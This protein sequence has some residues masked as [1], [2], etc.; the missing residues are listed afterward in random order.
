MTNPSTLEQIVMRRVYRMRYLRMV[1]NEF[2]A[3]LLLL[4]A[5]LWGLGREVWVAMVLHNAPADLLRAPAFFLSAFLDTR[6]VVQLLSMLVLAAV[7]LLAREAARLLSTVME[8]AR[9]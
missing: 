6:L 7:V 2:T 1:L 4:A 5:A 9:T 8:P 3:A